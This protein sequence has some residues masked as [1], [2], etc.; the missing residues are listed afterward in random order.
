MF[1]EVEQHIANYPFHFGL[2]QAGIAGQTA[3][4]IQ[5]QPEAFFLQQRP[6]RGGPLGQGFTEVGRNQIQLCPSVL[7]LGQFQHIINVVEERF[8]AIADVIDQEQLVRIKPAVFQQIGRTENTDQR[9]AQH[10]G[11]VG[12]E[13]VAKKG[14]VFPARLAMWRRILV[15]GQTIIRNTMIRFLILQ[16]NLPSSL[17]KL[18]NGDLT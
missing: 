9:C 1:H 7:E 2:V 14:L 13:A 10:V 16:F 17:Q 3:I 4:Q 11:Q 15:C 6:K 12:Q 5:L 18:A 8:P